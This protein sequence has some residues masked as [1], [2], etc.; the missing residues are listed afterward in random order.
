MRMKKIFLFLILG[1]FLIGVVSAYCGNE[2]DTYQEPCSKT[3]I[4]CCK[5]QTECES[6]SVGYYWYKD[7]TETTESCHSFSQEPNYCNGKGKSQLIMALNK[8]TN[9]H[10]ATNAVNSDTTGYNK[11]ICYGDFDEG[12]FELIGF[13]ETNVHDKIIDL[14]NGKNNV[15]TWLYEDINSHA[16]TSNAAPSSVTGG[17][18]YDFGVFYGNLICMPITTIKGTD[19]KY[20]VGCDEDVGEKPILSLY[21]NYNSHISKGA[22]E[23]YPIK[24]CCQPNYPTHLY[25]ADANGK[26][27]TKYNS[28]GY[29]QVDKDDEVTLVAKG[30]WSNTIVS[31][32]I[33]EQNKY[34]SDSRIKTL[35]D[36]GTLIWIAKNPTAS[37]KYY[38]KEKFKTANGYGP[39]LISNVPA[40]NK[41][42]TLV[43]TSTTGND[44]PAA[45]ITSPT[46]DT[47][48]VGSSTSFDIT[49]AQSSTDSDN[50]YLNYK[51]DFG[52]DSTPLTGN[53]NP[54]DPQY[55]SENENPTHTFNI[56]ADKMSVQRTITLTVDDGRTENKGED[57]DEITITFLRDGTWVIAEI[58]PLANN[59]V[60]GKVTLKAE[61]SYAI[62]IDGGTVNCLTGNNCPTTINTAS[63]TTPVIPDAANYPLT[64]DWKLY[65]GQTTAGTDSTITKTFAK[66]G[67]HTASLTVQMT[68]NDETKQEGYTEL[69]FATVNQNYCSGETL[70]DSNG[71]SYDTLTDNGKCVGEGTNDDCCPYG[72]QCKAGEEGD[73]TIVCRPDFEL[74]TQPLS[75]FS[76]SDYT[77]KLK[78]EL[79]Q[80]RVGSSEGGGIGTDS[81]GISVASSTCGDIVQPDSSCKCKWDSVAG[82]CGLE[83]GGVVLYNKVEYSYTCKTTVTTGECNNGLMRVT[84]TGNIEWAKETGEPPETATNCGELCS[85]GGE[86]N[87]ICGEAS[88]KLPF[89]S[90]FNLIISV[91]GIALIYVLKIKKTM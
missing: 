57:T 14:P 31:Y 29:P 83:V 7:S 40:S 3:Y 79:D 76:C 61:N 18:P 37:K 60:I 67:T 46:G 71:K 22:D 30:K 13:T 85:K 66:T 4:E 62:N 50:K 16:S 90:F 63:G 84:R 5:T 80:N 2:G 28:E 78:C 8:E 73:D 35:E 11:Q 89:F 1:L 69:S 74:L 9:S 12:D 77:D 54:D 34:T 17:Q 59:E 26:V 87:I 6:S 23:N 51:W 52:D 49:F 38:F 58:S 41:M 86:S 65:N 56:Y 45:K 55:N 20:P 21:Q 25:W 47:F 75:I 81:C 33:I 64:Y 19:G 24:I 32:E 36:K 48:L 70:W 42:G 43:V 10:G 82:T 68:M 72:Y 15:I 27:I 88:V 91:I 39:I 53:T 44:K